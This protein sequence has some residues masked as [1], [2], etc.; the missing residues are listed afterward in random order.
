MAL[1]IGTYYPKQVLTNEEIASWN[2]AISRDG[3]ALRTLTEEGI[4]RK[5]GVLGRHIAEAGENVVSMGVQAARK[6]VIEG[7]DVDFIFFSTSHPN[8]KDNGL[9]FIDTLKLTPKKGYLNVHAACSGYTLALS[10]IARDGSHFEGKSILVVGSEI[11]SPTIP[12]LREEKDP[13]LSQTI[14]SDGAAA[15]KFVYEKD[16]RVLSFKN[17]QFPE[18]VADSLKM[19]VDPDLV[20][21]PAIT[22]PIPKSDTGKFWMDGGRVYNAV[23]ASLPQLIMDTVN[24]ATFQPEDISLL[25]PHQGSR[26]MLEGLAKRLPGFNVFS[27]IEWGNFSSASIPKALLRAADENLVKKGDKLVLAGFGAGLFASVSVV[28]LN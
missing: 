10:E 17:Y 2:I 23:I 4:F 14:F 22:V 19:A 20:R 21:G 28:Q 18:D 1:E 24:D 6:L 16:L 27:D 7:E 9:E 12:D 13:S 26:H 3:E 8:G 11:Y 25:V 15:T 5:V